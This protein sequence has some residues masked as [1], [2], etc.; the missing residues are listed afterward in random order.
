MLF[1]PRKRVGIGTSGRGSVSWRIGQI[2]WIA[3]IVLF[4]AV[5]AVAMV[6]MVVEGRY[7][8]VGATPVISRPRLLIRLGFF[9]PRPRFRSGVLR[10]GW[11][12]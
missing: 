9:P 6:A 11:F 3:G 5:A 10:S 12:G 4:A 2:A 8:A 7:D 1:L